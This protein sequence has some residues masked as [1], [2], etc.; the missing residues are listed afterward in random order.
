MSGDQPFYVLP[1]TALDDSPLRAIFKLQ[2]TV[3][4]KK[5]YQEGRRHIEHRAG[6]RRPDRR[7]HRYEVAIR[8]FIAE[9]LLPQIVTQR[10]GFVRHADV[11]DRLPVEPQNITHHAMKRR[12]QH[13]A[14]LRKEPVER[15]AVVLDQVIFGVHT[16]AH[17]A[18]LR[19]LTDLVEQLDEIG[20][21]PIVEDNKSGINR[22]RLTGF[23][24]IDGIRVPADVRRGLKHR[25]IELI[26]QL[27][28]RDIAG[29]AGANYCQAHERAP[30]P[31]TSVG[32]AVS[33]L[34]RSRST[35]RIRSARRSP[36]LRLS[37]FAP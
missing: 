36:L 21:S 15:G 28:R 10:H 37:G 29:N 19:G 12:P 23:V 24:N 27:V 32:R 26:A 17:L 11:R 1:G 4:F 2:Q 25:D 7:D 3:V 35:P 5:S 31:T 30:P 33:C 6:L 14:P 9:G 16:E 22:E 20:V 13:I 18:G 34:R 8:E